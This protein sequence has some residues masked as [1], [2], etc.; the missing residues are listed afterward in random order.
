MNEIKKNIAYVW[1]LAK[2]NDSKDVMTKESKASSTIKQLLN[3]GYCIKRRRP[4]VEDIYEKS[5]EVANSNDED[6]NTLK[7]V[8]VEQL[9]GWFNEYQS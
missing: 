7:N 5:Q 3:D 6:Q 8:S 1:T 9:D 2:G 4:I